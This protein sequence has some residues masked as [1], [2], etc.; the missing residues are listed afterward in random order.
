MQNL[1]FKMDVTNSLTY[2]D[3]KFCTGSEEPPV[4]ELQ[5]LPSNYR[6]LFLMSANPS[7]KKQLAAALAMHPAFIKPTKSWL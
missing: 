7:A 2:S 4:E 1:G 5:Q 6:A 3:M